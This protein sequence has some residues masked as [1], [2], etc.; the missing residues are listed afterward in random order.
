[1][2]TELIFGASLKSNTPTDVINAISYMIG[3]PT[4][5]PSNYP[6]DDNDMDVLLSSSYYFGV[7]L[8]VRKFWYDTITESWCLSTRSNVKNYSNEIERF[9]EWIKPYI[10]SGSGNREMYAIVIYEDAETPTIYY[11]HDKPL[12]AEY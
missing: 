8:P 2:Y 6:F 9:L 1:M 5:K 3:E 4:D 7:S 11:L 10:E 12:D